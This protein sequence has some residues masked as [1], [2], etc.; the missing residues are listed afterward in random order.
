[1]QKKIIALAV[2]ALASSAAMAQSNVTVYG[3]AD[4]YVGSVNASG[5][6]KQR[7]TV[8]NSG[9]L[10]TSR[11]GFKGTEDLG[12][13]LKALFTVETAVNFDVNGSE[14]A[15]ASSANSGLFGAN[16]QSF[17]GLTGGFGTA[18]AGRLQTTG[19]DWGVKFGGGL[20][21]T[22]LSPLQNLTTSSGLIGAT[23]ATAARLDNA[24][25]YIT[26]TFGGFSAAVNYTASAGAQE[27]VTKPN[28]NSTAWMASGTYENGPFAAG[29][30]YAKLN[31]ATVGS[32]RADWALGTS[33]DLGVAKLAATYQTTKLVDDTF[34]APANNRDKVF[35]L[36]ASVPVTAAGAVHLQYAKNSIG[37]TA[38]SDN[39]SG[40]AVAYTHGLSKRTTAY[41]GYSTVSNAAGTVARTATY[42]A[43]Q[44]L[45]VGNNATG[46]APDA[47]KNS[48]ILAAGIRHSF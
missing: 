19:Y 35:S 46:Y 8:V 23:N 27:T 39:T 25:A 17:V 42:A 20:A 6:A 33:Y 47:G 24:V 26:P 18:V 7:T 34:T 44:T 29:L 11:L 5:V 9:G 12:N 1:M 15:T 4:M 41:A 38:A 48:S 43:G 13:G 22:S 28:A 45:A 16:R 36:S 14:T 30:V 3:I 31:S 40:Y 2:A 21:G 10:S 37:S 32:D